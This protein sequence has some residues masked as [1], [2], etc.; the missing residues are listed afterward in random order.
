MI[1]WCSFFKKKEEG[2]WNAESSIKQYI[3]VSSVWNCEITLPLFLLKQ[4]SRGRGVISLPFLLLNKVGQKTGLEI[5]GKSQYWKSHVEKVKQS[6]FSSMLE[7][8]CTV[9]LDLN[10]E[11]TICQKLLWVHL[12]LTVLFSHWVIG[13]FFDDI[14][15]IFIYRYHTKMM[16]CTEKT[17]P[18]Y[19]TLPV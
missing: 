8:C 6:H 2:N 17:D 18:N 19:Y 15:E 12:H 10:L 13:Y 14:L 4:M 3:N 7:S 11:F 16:F 9:K 1:R 5:T